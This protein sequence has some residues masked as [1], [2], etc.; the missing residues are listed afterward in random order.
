MR[1]CVQLHAFHK[2]VPPKLRG[3]ERDGIFQDLGVMNYIRYDWDENCTQFG[4][5]F[6]CLEFQGRHATRWSIDL[7]VRTWF[8]VRTLQGYN[9]EQLVNWRSVVHSNRQ[10]IAVTLRYAVSGAYVYY[11]YV[12]DSAEVALP[13][14][15]TLQNRSDVVITS[16]VFDVVIS[17][18]SRHALHEAQHRLTVHRF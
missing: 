2:L 1:D 9:C 12:S 17:S 14:C 10:Y 7:F 15:S 13:T 5:Y 6:P 4:S 8:I 18:D 11:V 3:K 16:T